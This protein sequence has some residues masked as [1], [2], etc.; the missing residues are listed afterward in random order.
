VGSRYQKQ[1]REGGKAQSGQYMTGWAITFGFRADLIGCPVVLM[2]SSG[3]L[4]GVDCKISH[5]RVR[6]W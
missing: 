5:R 2:G 3:S 4:R 1:N 6:E